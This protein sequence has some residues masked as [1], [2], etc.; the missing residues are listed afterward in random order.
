MRGIYR[1]AQM[2]LAGDPE[3][4]KI[5]IAIRLKQKIKMEQD[6]VQC[7]WLQVAERLTLI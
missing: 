6:C 7:F 4:V 2:H 5:Q 1:V 3:V